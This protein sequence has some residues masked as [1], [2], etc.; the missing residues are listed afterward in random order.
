V[1]RSAPLISNGDGGKYNNFFTVVCVTN[2][3]L[4]PQTPISFGGST[5]V[6]YEYVNVVPNPINRFKP[7]HCHIFNRIEF[8]TPADTL[9]VLTSCHNAV[10]PEGQEGYLVVSAQDPSLFNT[11]WGH[12]Y[13]MGSEFVINESGGVYSIN[14]IPFKAQVA[15]GAPT[16]VNGNAQLDFDGV[17]Y[18]GIPDILYIDSFIA[19]ARSQLALINLTGGSHDINTVQFNVWND[20]EFPLSATR[21]FKCWFDQP[22][23]RV[24]PLFDESFL[25]Y[26][27]PNDP[28]ELDVECSGYGRAE[29]GWARIDSIS[30]RTEG[31]LFVSND[32]ALLGAITAG[33]SSTFDGGHLLWESEAKQFNGVAFNP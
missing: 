29:T 31:G 23:Y 18:E 9:C 27:T 1:H 30:V 26:N 10:S 6:H 5:L 16:D 17:E 22:L 19:L 20:N 12:D 2:I 33:D 21:A 7:L 28:D 15:A 11:A 4:L 32:G 13:L 24:S 25:R 3:N 14:A 8:L